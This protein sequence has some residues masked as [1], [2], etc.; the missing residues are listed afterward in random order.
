MAPAAARPRRRAQ[1]LDGPGPLNDAALSRAATRVFPPADRPRIDRA[2]VIRPA[3]GAVIEFL[4]NYFDNSFV[5]I[6]L[7]RDDCIYISSQVGD[8][9]PPED[10]STPE[11]ES[12]KG[13][14]L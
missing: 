5:E 11:D 3:S 13:G 9:S 7:L 8:E 14:S 2:L 12:P 10:Y 1:A 6:D 4:S